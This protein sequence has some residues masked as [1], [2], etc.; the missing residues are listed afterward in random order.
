MRATLSFAVSLREEGRVLGWGHLTELGASCRVSLTQASV[1]LEFPGIFAPAGANHQDES[2]LA[3]CKILGRSY[4]GAAIVEIT[5]DVDER[6]NAVLVTFRQERRSSWEL[7]GGE[8]ARAS[9]DTKPTG[10]TRGRD[11]LIFSCNWKSFRPVIILQ[12]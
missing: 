3:A 1:K 2:W 6:T 4:A 9:Y 10:G 11:F 8:P 5:E 7:L 12:A